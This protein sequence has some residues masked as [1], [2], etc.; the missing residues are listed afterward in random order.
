MSEPTH[1][2]ETVITSEQARRWARSPQGRRML[3]VLTKLP[4]RPPIAG[5][6]ARGGVVLPDRGTGPTFFLDE[7]H[8][9][10]PRG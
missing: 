10:P 1:E 7:P 9:E 5:S 4:H 8:A 3:E 6:Y 2:T